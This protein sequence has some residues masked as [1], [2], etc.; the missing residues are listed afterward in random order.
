M[1]FIHIHLDNKLI[2]MQSDMVAENIFIDVSKV[3]DIHKFTQKVKFLDAK[4]IEILRNK[5]ILIW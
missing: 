3:K 2:T 1:A 4:N 5:K